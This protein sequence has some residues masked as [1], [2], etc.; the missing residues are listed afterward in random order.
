MEGS[1]KSNK[2][3]FSCDLQM[4]LGSFCEALRIIDVRSG[5]G[6]GSQDVSPSTSPSMGFYWLRQW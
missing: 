1:L 5:A 2:S 4:H 6:A 3:D